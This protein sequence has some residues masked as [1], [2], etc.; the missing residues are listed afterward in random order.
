MDLRMTRLGAIIS[1]PSSSRRRSSNASLSQVPVVPPDSRHRKRLALIAAEV[2]RE[3]GQEL[4]P[5][6]SHGVGRACLQSR[7]TVSTAIR[8]PGGMSATV[9]ATD[10]SCRT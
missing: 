6:T 7:E 10:G 4:P 2:P 9:G 1:M 8:A 3:S 5:N